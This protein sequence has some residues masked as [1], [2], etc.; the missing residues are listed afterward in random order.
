[1]PVCP[2]LHHSFIH[3]LTCQIPLR[4]EPFLG[5]P[6]QF[7]PELG[8]KELEVLVDAYVVGR[9]SKSDKLSVV[10]FEFFNLATVDLNT[11]ALVRTGS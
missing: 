7:Q 9:G 5:A 6:L 10:T 3:L 11:G 1:M 8:S 2:G 4:V